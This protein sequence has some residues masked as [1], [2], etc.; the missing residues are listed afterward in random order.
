MANGPL[1]LCPRFNAIAPC[2][3][4]LDGDGMPDLISGGSGDVPWSHMVRFDNAPT[5]EVRGYLA[6]GGKKIYHEYVH[7]DDTTFPFAID[8][9]GDGLIDIL[10]G[11]GDGFVTFYRNEGSKTDAKFAAGVKL[12]TTDG[13][14]MCVGDPTPEH[15]SDFESH[16]GNRSVPAP[17]DYDGDGKSDVILG[18]SGG[19]RGI[20]LNRGMGGDDGAPKFEVVKIKDMPWLPSPRPI[21]MDWDRDGDTDVLWASSYSLLHFASRDFMEHGY[22]KARLRAK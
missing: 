16:S 4:D 5:F 14:P 12:K 20:Y 18:W 9:D 13:K 7:G 17:A 10:M 21:A 22:V 19:P 11:D 3:G 6:A 1:I 2:F 15:A 8:F